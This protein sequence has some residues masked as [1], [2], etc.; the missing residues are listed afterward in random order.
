MEFMTIKLLMMKWW[1]VERTLD[2][3]A[4]LGSGPKLTSP[5]VVVTA[6]AKRSVGG[7]FDR[8]VLDCRPKL[9]EEAQLME[10]RSAVLAFHETG[11]P[12]HL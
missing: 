9:A 12:H 4:H 2:R 10:G 6:V 11:S 8:W 5:V 1:C 7:E 3:I